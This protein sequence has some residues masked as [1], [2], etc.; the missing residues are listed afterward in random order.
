MLPTGKN[1]QAHRPSPNP[2]TPDHMEQELPKPLVS[3]WCA[4][5]REYFTYSNESGCLLWATRKSRQWAKSIGQPAGVEYYRDSGRKKSVRVTV[6]GRLHPVHRIIWEMHHGPI[7][8]GILI[9]HVDGNPFN[10]RLSNLRAVSH[11]QNTV[12]SRV[13]GT[14]SRVKGVSK[15][16]EPSNLPWKVKLVFGGIT[17]YD[18]YFAFKS[19]AARAY[20]KQSLRWHGKNSLYYRNA[21]TASLNPTPTTEAK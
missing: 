17:R 13:Y 10:N 20:A 18:K 2:P 7:P 14:P 11:A 5:W 12:N 19:D 9:D 6:K 15:R 1:Y 4:V 3:D 8:D 16:K 21:W